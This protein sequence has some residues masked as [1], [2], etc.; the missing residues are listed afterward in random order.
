MHQKYL[1]ILPLLVNPLVNRSRS[2]I[3][4]NLLSF[5]NQILG[6]KNSFVQREVNKPA[7]EAAGANPPQWISTDIGK[8]NQFSKI[9][10]SF[11]PMMCS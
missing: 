10:V 4:T 2:L 7:A 3:T 8:I 6:K 5:P 9:G 1:S 11:E